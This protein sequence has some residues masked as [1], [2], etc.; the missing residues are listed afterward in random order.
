VGHL[1]DLCS[2]GGH[3][4][5]AGYESIL[6]GIATNDPPIPCEAATQTNL[7]SIG[8]LTPSLDDPGWVVRIGRSRVSAVLPVECRRESE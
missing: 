6:M 3:D 4:G 5:L 1:S 7:E 2:F 8:A